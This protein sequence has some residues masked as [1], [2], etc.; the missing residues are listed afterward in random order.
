MSPAAG[1][2]GLLPVYSCPVC[3]V[4]AS[5]FGEAMALPLTFAVGPDGKPFDPA[6]PDGELAPPA[7]QADA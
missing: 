7:P 3:T 4:A 5:M 1:H 6:T 2:G